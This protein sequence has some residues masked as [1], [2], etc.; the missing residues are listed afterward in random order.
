MCVSAPLFG[1]GLNELCF[2][3]VSRLFARGEERACN[4]E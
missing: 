4:V 3:D 1:E 2:A